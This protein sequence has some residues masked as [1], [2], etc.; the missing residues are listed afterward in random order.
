MMGPVGRFAL[1]QRFWGGSLSRVLLWH[2]GAGV[3]EADALSLCWGGGGQEAPSVAPILAVEL[4][5]VRIH[6]AEFWGPRRAW[7][8][9]FKA[10]P[11]SEL[12][13]RPSLDQHREQC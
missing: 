8:R 6:E 13:R 4:T 5:S 11:H 9:E 1:T 10:L 2:E 3:R 12:V 7:P